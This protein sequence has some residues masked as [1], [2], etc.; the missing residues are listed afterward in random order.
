M[1]EVSSHSPK[2]TATTLT[3]PWTAFYIDRAVRY[4]Q[5]FLRFA[6]PRH[7]LAI[8]LLALLSM[9]VIGEMPTLWAVITPLPFLAWPV[10]LYGSPASWAIMRRRSSRS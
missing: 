8:L 2:R 3:T 6:K 10:W 9:V 1:L 7:H 5:I 4:R